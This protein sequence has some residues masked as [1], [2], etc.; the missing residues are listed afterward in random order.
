MVVDALDEC[1]EANGT[2]VKLLAALRSLGMTVNL[3]VTSCITT[4]LEQD[5]RGAQRLTI[6]ADAEDVRKFIE[7]Q[8][9]FEP[10]LSRH[11]KRSKTLQAE[12]VKSVNTKIDGV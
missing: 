5:L 2:R 12:I 1:S 6:R 3:L 11:V 8:I 10:R 4:S 9:P 7:H